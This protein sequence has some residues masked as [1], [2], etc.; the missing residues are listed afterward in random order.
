MPTYNIVIS[1]P[2]TRRTFQKEIDI[3]GSGLIGKKIRDRVPGN[4]LGLAGYEL[5]VTGGSDK[6][7]F[8]MRHDVHGTARK[9]V[10]LSFGPGFH[11]LRKGQ[12]KKKSVRGNTISQDIVQ[13]N[14]KIVKYGEK[15]VEEML[16]IKP[17]EEGKKEGEK[18]GEKKP[19]EGHKAEGA[20]ERPAEE[21]K[22]ESSKAGAEEKAA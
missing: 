21:S 9:R 19:K 22:E 6:E 17:K 20:E 14:T 10:L 8:P 2:K 13:V 16:G 12:R 15:P 11:P 7:G 1:D 18:T 5:E 3:A 4:S